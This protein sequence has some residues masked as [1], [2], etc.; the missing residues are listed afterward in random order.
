MYENVGARIPESIVR[1][2]DYVAKQERTD[3]SKVIRELLSD[4]V[5]K[6]LIDMALE[7]YSKRDVSLGRAAELAKI[8]LSDF[9]KVAADRKIPMNYSKESLKKDFEAALKQK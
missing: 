2:I 5:K 8:P 1:A 7:K 9:M 3:K 4:A 6:K